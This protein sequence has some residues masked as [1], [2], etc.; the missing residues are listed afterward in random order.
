M[1]RIS[2]IPRNLEEIVGNLEDLCLL[3][4]DVVDMLLYFVVVAVKNIMKNIKIMKDHNNI[5]NNNEKS[6]IENSIDFSIT[7]LVGF[8]YGSPTI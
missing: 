5:E 8:N 7:S 1:F 2:L 6:K 3:Y 4:F